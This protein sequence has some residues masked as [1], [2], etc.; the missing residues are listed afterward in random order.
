MEIFIQIGKIQMQ[1]TCKLCS[2][3]YLTTSQKPYAPARLLPDNLG[4]LA[5]F[6]HFDSR[7]KDFHKKFKRIKWSQNIEKQNNSYSL[8]KIN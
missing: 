6:L 3:F 5:Y 2:F 4:K 1:I 7:R 8:D